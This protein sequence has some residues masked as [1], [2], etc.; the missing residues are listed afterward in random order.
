MNE[1]P[2]REVQETHAVGANAARVDAPGKVTGRTLYP[3]DITYPD[4]LHMATLFAGRVHSRVLSI[5]TS[6][7]E[8]APGVVAVFTAKDVPVN[9]YGLQIKDQPVLCGPGSAIP[10]TDVVRFVGDQVVVARV[11]EG[12]VE[13]GERAKAMVNS[14]RRHQTA[15]NH[16]ATHLLHNAL[17]IVLGEGVRQAGSMVTPDKLRFDYSTRQ[18][19]TPEQLR[20]IEELANRRIVENHQVRPFVTTREYAAE[21]GALAFFEEKYG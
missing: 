16:T 6:A 18:S 9:A 1:R 2:D 7:A 8:A 15:C 21:L 4:Q 17:R 20:Q 19:P 11:T 14:V 12:K 5:D 10:G 13:A 3:G